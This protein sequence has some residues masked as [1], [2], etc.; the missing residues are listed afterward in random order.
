MG[1]FFFVFGVVLVQQVLSFEK[2]EFGVKKVVLVVFFRKLG[3]YNIY[4][5]YFFLFRVVYKF[6][7]SY[8]NFFSQ[9]RMSKLRLRFMYFYRVEFVGFVCFVFEVVSI[10]FYR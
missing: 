9:I 4:F 7:G 1:F 6:K 2:R 3:S 8:V 5:K 10:I